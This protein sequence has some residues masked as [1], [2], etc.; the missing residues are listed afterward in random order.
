MKKYLFLLLIPMMLLGCK[1]EPANP[2]FAEFD[3]PFNLPPFEQIKNEHFVPAFEEAIRQQEEVIA[4]IVANEEPATFANTIEELEY[5]SPMLT[6]VSRVFFNFNSALISPEIQAIA[7]QVSPMLS[8]HRD[9]IMLNAEL[10]ARIKA[11]YDQK[12]QLGLNPEQMRLLT[13][14]YQQFARNGALLPAEKQARFREINQELSLLSLQYSENMLGDVNAFRMVIENEADLAGLP[15]SAIASAAERATAEGH[16]GKWVFTLHNPSVMPFLYN[17]HNRELREKMQTAF[18]NRGN[19]NNEFDNKKIAAQITNLRIER[20]QMLG[21]QNHAHFILEETMAQNIDNV[22]NFIDQVWAPGLALAKTEAARMQ[23]MIRAAGRTYEL[24]QWDWR[25]Y[26]EKIRQQH[27][28]LDEEEVRQ[29]FELNSVRDGIFEI[30]RRLW[31]L[32]FVERNDLPKYHPDVQ[33]FEVLEADNSH[34]GILYM[35]FHPRESKRGGAWMSSFR[36]QQVTREG[37]F[38]HPV[39]T[40]VCNFTPPTATT[41]SLLTYDEMITFFHEFGHALHGLLSNVT[42]P[43][44]AGTSVPRDFVELPAQIME[45]WARDPK[46]KEIYA[47]HYQTGEPIPADLMERIIKAQHFN[48]GFA[49]VE[50]LAST[51]LDLE[52]HTLTEP[53]A[54]DQLMEVTSIINQR[55][56]DRI[57]LIPQINFRHGST[58]FSHIFPG[59]YSA[60]YYSYM[61]SGLLDADAYAAFVETG[62]L[63]NQE[64]AQRF[65]ETILERGGTKD[66]RQLWLDFRGRDPEI[67][68]LLRQRGLAQ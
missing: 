40:I 16:E 41:P 23:E 63:F 64:V 28:N 51:Y 7:Q 10:F 59:G 27:Y 65:R 31:G 29:Y 55:T 47:R 25:Y 45:N 3:T 9:N 44:L 46:I 62:D 13:E 5:S 57:G 26:A 21:F 11:V 24:Q 1:R 20:A 4:A 61:W 2:F 30:V 68:H 60:G 67:I 32:Q 38:I 37:E 18:V 36:G 14:T 54:E 22:V 35:D 6:R 52:Y 53:F 50:F 56:I 39:I 8:A 34:V 43:S 17:A 49:T 12:D 15:E 66:A 19:N 58:H 33:V 48:Q 42:F